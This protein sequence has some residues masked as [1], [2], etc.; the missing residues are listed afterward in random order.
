MRSRCLLAIIV[1][2][3]F[4][5]CDLGNAD[6]GNDTVRLF[7]LDGGNSGPG[8]RQSGRMM[9]GGMM[10]AGLERGP[11]EEDWSSTCGDVL[12]ESCV[13]A[14]AALTSQRCSVLATSTLLPST[15]AGRYRQDIETASISCS[16]RADV[17]LKLNTLGNDDAARRSVNASQFWS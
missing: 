17:G 9:A 13:L 5:H 16:T 11:D 2:G 8:R 6:D 12:R 15:V 14:E 1:A 10:G 7:R 3:G 4:S